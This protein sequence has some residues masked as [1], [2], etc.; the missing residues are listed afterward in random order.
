[1][2]DRHLGVR[3]YGRVIGQVA[4][5]HSGRHTLSYDAQYVTDINSTPLSLSMPPAAAS[6][7]GRR[8]GP[9]LAGLLPDGDEV[10]E[11]WAQMFD[12]SA[13]NSFALLEHMGLDC[14]GA[15]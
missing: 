5:S 9:Y 10:R 11:R 1:V 7:P 4:Q 15:V 6:Y 14:A 8:I 2:T 12:V 13:V 3:L